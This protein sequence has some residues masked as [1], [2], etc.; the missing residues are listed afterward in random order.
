MSPAGAVP[1]VPAVAPPPGVSASASALAAS[2]LTTSPSLPPLTA[3]APTVLA[4][5]PE[6]MML[7]VLMMCALPSFSHEGSGRFE[8]NR[9]GTHR[10]QFEP[11]FAQRDH[12]SAHR[13]LNQIAQHEGVAC[14]D[15][16]PAFI[17]TTEF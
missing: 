14:L 10:K 15:Q 3:R 12:E 16:A 17:K 4:M 13:Q 1:N 7:M 2:R 9:L 8:S 11:F 5:F 6:P